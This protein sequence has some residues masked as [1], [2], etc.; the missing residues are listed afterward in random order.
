[1][2]AVCQYLAYNT[3]RFLTGRIRRYGRA[4]VSFGAPLSLRDWLAHQPADVLR[5]PRAERLPHIQRLA[6][7]MLRRIAAIVPVTPVP[8]AAAV[9][10]SF[11]RDAVPL[12]DV[13]RRLADYRDHLREANATMV[14]ADRSV[15]ET[16]ERAMLMFRMR[17]TVTVEGSTVVVFARQRPLLE[18]Y[19]NAIRHLL[20]AGALPEGQLLSPAHDLGE[21]APKY[22]LRPPPEPRR[23]AGPG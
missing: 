22:R 21:I 13:L 16:W 19:A 3:A 4:A 8:L 15:E 17:R 11:E 23:P 20:P 12:A 2:L 5:L 1:V 6:D 10:L 7:A 9:L 14:R 18:Y